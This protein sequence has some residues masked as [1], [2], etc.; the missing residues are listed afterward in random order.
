MTTDTSPQRMIGA[1]IRATNRT[2]G[3][4]PARDAGDPEVVVE[5]VNAYDLTVRT[6]AGNVYA[7]GDYSIVRFRTPDAID[8]D[9]RLRAAMAEDD[10]LND[11]RRN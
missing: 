10:A 6:D 9:E 7:N 1:T 5:V 3:L 4:A 11:P 8:A 2:H